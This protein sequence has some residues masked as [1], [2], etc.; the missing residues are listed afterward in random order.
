[1]PRESAKL[2]PIMKL[3]FITFVRPMFPCPRPTLASRRAPKQ[4]Q[5]EVRA[6]TPRALRNAPA[7]ILRPLDDCPEAEERQSSLH[8]PSSTRL[9]LSRPFD[10]RSPA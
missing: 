6:A 2:L 7:P 8:R 5:A 10:G 3:F 9:S 4:A 1:M